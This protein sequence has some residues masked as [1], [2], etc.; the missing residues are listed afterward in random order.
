M[1]QTVLL[2]NFTDPDRLAKVKQALLPLG[3]RLKAVQKEDYR[4]PVGALAGVKG[5]EDEAAAEPLGGEGD[6]GRAFDFNDEMAVM[7]GFTSAQVDALIR[8]LRRV[9][10]GRIDYKAVL[11][12]Y[13]KNWDSVR[14][15]REIRKEHE[16]MSAAADE[17][18]RRV[19]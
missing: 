2:Y 10:V 17:R 3:F 16:S 7:A 12:P 18:Q 4:R 15:Y 9:G 14:L 11:T 5:M 6:E 8:A 1:K 13:N 19:T